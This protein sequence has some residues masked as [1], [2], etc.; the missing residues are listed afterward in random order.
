MS[1]VVL[2]PAGPCLSYDELD[3]IIIHYLNYLF[4]HPESARSSIICFVLQHKV[5]KT[6]FPSSLLTELTAQCSMSIGLISLGC[7]TNVSNVPDPN[8][9][10]DSGAG[11][12]RGCS[13]PLW[14]DRRGTVNLEDQEPE[15]CVFTSLLLQ[16]MSP[17]CKKIQFS[18][19]PA[20]CYYLREQPCT[21]R[22]GRGRFC[23]WRVGKPAPV[24][25]AA[26]SGPSGLWGSV[27]VQ[28]LRARP[29]PASARQA[30]LTGG[31]GG[32][33]YKYSAILPFL[34]TGASTVTKTQIVYNPTGAHAAFLHECMNHQ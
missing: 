28:V 2:F 18:A 20:F 25:H 10:S 15:F 11:V 7:E 32:P 34:C 17:R 30:P 21:D 12:T 27:S 5:R 26:S 13:G 6:H 19:A 31:E 24:V 4:T 8:Q 22:D 14:M 23:G 33:A 9:E 1:P 29:G 16:V 3:D